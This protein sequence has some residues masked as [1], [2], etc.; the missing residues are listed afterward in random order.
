MIVKVWN[1][2]SLTYKEIFQDELIEIPPHGFVSM[3]RSKAVTFLGGYRPFQ[4]DGAQENRGEKPLRLEEDVE[5]L[6]EKYDQ[7]LKYHS[8][9]GTNFRTKEGLRKHEE[10]LTVK[11]EIITGSEES[12]K[13]KKA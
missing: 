6:A 8:S 2:S 9:D 12:V 5:A 3:P 11:R 7:P 4:R 13:R 10:S 1:D